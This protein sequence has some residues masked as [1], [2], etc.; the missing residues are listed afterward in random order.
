MQKVLFI[1]TGNYYRSRFAEILFNA[2]AE[3]TKL[4][5]RAESRGFASEQMRNVGPISPYVLEGL[6]QRG[7]QS[8][9]AVRFPM[10]LQEKD[11]AQADLIIALKENEHR[12]Y[13]ER[14]F[15]EWGER[16]AYWN[17]HD[18]DVTSAP[19]TLAQIEQQVRALIQRLRDP[20]PRG[21]IA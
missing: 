15:R 6:A 18:L 4:D 3:E 2:L 17:V 8:E 11:L 16:V 5:W 12:P 9:G 21:G 19:E 13:F 1:C 10:Q 14:Y 7:I 20:H